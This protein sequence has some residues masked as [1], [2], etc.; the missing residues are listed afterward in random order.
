[1][2][3]NHLAGEETGAVESLSEEIANSASDDEDFV[4]REHPETGE[5]IKIS[6]KAVKMHVQYC[7]G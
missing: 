1:V 5:E 2:G 3:R 6:K 7:I 4:V